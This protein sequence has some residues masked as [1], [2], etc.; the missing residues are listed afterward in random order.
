VL[1]LG[2]VNGEKACSG[3]GLRR[4]RGL[5]LD[6]T[7]RTRRYLARLIRDWDAGNLA[8]EDLS[9]VAHSLRILANMIEQPE[10]LRRLDALES[11]VRELTQ[12]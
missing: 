11:R 7:P 1:D 2:N 12:P 4:S 9:R 6:S 5:Q 10:V 3:N 8:S